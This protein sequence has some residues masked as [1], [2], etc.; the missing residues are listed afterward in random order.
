MQELTEEAMD[1]LVD[2]ASEY[3]VS[4]NLVP[5]IYLE[6]MMDPMMRDAD[7]LD[8]ANMV[9]ILTRYH[10]EWLTKQR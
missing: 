3:A 10:E 4:R 8:L 9:A 5:K 6:G 2:L 7:R 1:R